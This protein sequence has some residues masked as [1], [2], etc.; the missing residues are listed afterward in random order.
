MPSSNFLSDDEM[1]G[2]SGEDKELPE[3]SLE[4]LDDEVVLATKTELKSKR[5][6]NRIRR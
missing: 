3:T 1:T 4:I 2:Q 5:D 6:K